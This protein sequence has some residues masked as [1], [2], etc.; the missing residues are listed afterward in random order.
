MIS[1]AL[2]KLVDESRTKQVDLAKYL[3]ITPSRLSNYM[4]GKREPSYQMLTMMAKY[5]GVGMDVFSQGEFK[6]T[7]QS[8]PPIDYK[9][10]NDSATESIVYIPIQPLNAKKKDISYERIPF[11]LDL[12]KG[13][14]EPENNLIVL[15]SNEAIDGL[16]DEGDYIIVAK[17]SSVGKLNT[18]DKLVEN[19]RLFRCYTYI[20]NKAHSLLIEYKN[21]QVNIPVPDSSKLRDF[22]KV[23]LLIKKF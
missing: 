22:Y 18:G 7:Q 16:S 9:T 5:F 13:V 17:V 23:V 20:N 12:F 11:P 6:Y 8:R 2:Q 10:L 3:G 19:G 4:R 15:V 1:K 21:P 14:K